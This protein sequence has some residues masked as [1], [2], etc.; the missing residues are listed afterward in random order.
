MLHLLA[1]LSGSIS[2]RIRIRLTN[3][4]TFLGV[5]VISFPLEVIDTTPSIEPDDCVVWASSLSGILGL[6]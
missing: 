1:V 2:I 4:R 6:V 5:V 3:E